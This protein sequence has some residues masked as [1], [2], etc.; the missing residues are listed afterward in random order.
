[1]NVT[2]HRDAAAANAAA[3]DLVCSWLADPCV[4]N[5]MLAA[6]N[7][8]LELYRLIGERRL[9]LSH[10]NLFALDEYVGV[11]N[12]NMHL[13]AGIGK[14]ARVL[15]P[16]PGEWRWMRRA[17]P[18]PWFPNFSLYR[19]PQSRDWS[20]ALQELRGDLFKGRNAK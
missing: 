18:S 9:P 15:V 1:M 16:Y 7:T 3:A 6:G 14:T 10:L 8:P 2:V 4:R 5:V 20:G 19:Q 12:A 11:S 13:L 17:G